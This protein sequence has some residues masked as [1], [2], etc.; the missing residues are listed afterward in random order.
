[1]TGNSCRLRS[2]LDLTAEIIDSTEDAHDD[3]G[4]IPAGEVI[5]AEVLA[6]DAFY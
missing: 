3:F 5:D 1:M 4:L 6:F 2:D